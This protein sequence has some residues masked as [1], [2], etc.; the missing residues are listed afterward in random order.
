M[1]LISKI[2]STTFGIG[3]CPIAPGTAASLFAL[4]IYWFL[5]EINNL[6][7]LSLIIFLFFI[8]VFTATITEKESI[9]RLG[10]EKGHDPSIIVIDEVIGELIAVFTIPK[11][12]SFFIAVFILFRLFDI[13]KPFPIN[14]SQKIPHG[15]GIV[16]DD[17]I[18][19]IST[20]IL[21]QIFILI[22]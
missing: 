3:Y 12:I 11:T 5:P 14:A 13:F 21:I 6:I 9:K 15:W 18:A 1:R 22:K 10:S 17:V 8:G 16:I 7:F 19:G 4:L 2:I 20:N